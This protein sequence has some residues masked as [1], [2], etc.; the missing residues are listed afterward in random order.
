MRV[1]FERERA[2]LAVIPRFAK[3]SNRRE[4][5]S[6]PDSGERSKKDVATT[7]KT[8]GATNVTDGVNVHASQTWPMSAF[9][10]ISGSAEFGL[11]GGQVHHGR[12]DSQPGDLCAEGEWASAS[13]SWCPALNRV[14][15]MRVSGCC[16]PACLA[17]RRGDT[18]RYQRGRCSHCLLPCSRNRLGGSRRQ[19][20]LRRGSLRGF[21]CCTDP[22]R[23]PR[24]CSSS[25]CRARPRAERA[26]CAT[27]SCRRAG[28]LAPFAPE[29]LGLGASR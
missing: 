15:G 22:A 13:A 17:Q 6:L 21:C 24:R 14:E 9:L 5:S 2:P 16:G 26:P 1:L 18:A 10:S 19:Q 25:A 29:T 20:R 7:G 8:A 12:G 28:V 23:R 27:V 3:W 11:A 4:D